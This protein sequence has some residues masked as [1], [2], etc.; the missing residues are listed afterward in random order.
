MGNVADLLFELATTDRL[1]ILSEIDSRPMRLTKVAKML[2]STVQATSRQIERLCEAKLIERNSKGDYQLTQFG[3]L[4]LTLLPAFDFIQDKKDYL[5]TH[6]LSFLPQE[7]IQRIGQLTEHEN[8]DN[9]DSA[10]AYVGVTFFEAKQYLR[11]MTDAVG[12][13]VTHHTWKPNPEKIEYM[14]ILPKSI[15]F[16][17]AVEARSRSYLP[18]AEV[19]VAFLDYPKATIVLSEKKAIVAFP[20][21]NGEVDIRSWIA[22][23]NPSFHKWCCDLF[24]FYWDRAEK[25][26]QVLG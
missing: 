23:E 1:A 18:A 21:L 6:D 16:P 22:G 7:F 20:L 12:A 13:S 5:L 2:S 4:A 9:L 14:L 3:K 11:C 26:S 24:N 10:L 17:K 15:S 25:R 8:L 19:E